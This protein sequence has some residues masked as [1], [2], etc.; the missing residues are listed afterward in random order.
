[1]HFIFFTT[2]ETGYYKMTKQF[3]FLSRESKGKM[4]E[5]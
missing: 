5:V 1:M 4:L 2:I 3:D